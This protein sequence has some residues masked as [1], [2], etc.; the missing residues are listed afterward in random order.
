MKTNLE[1]RYELE[2]VFGVTMQP[3]DWCTD[4]WTYNFSTPEVYILILDGSYRVSFGGFLITDDIK[5]VI[6]VFKR[7]SDNPTDFVPVF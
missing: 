7:L 1:L 5:E 3:S 4:C 6:K 2:G